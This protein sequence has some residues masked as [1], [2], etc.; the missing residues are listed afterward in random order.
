MPGNNSDMD[1]VCDFCKKSFTQTTI[2]RHIGQSQAC[3]A[4]YGPRFKE[5]KKKKATM[6]T[7]N[8][9][10][11]LTRKEKKKELKR[12]RILYANNPVKKE[13]N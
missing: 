12:N 8:W 10:N 2:L 7:E 11:N 1:V 3:K 13:K 4:F 9:K 6:R 5:M